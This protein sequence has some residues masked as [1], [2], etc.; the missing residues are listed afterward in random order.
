MNKL[1]QVFVW[2]LRAWPVIIL[3]LLICAHIALINRYLN[4]WSLIN[5]TISL[6]TQITGGLII[7][8]SI[9]SNIGIIKKL[10]L[11]EICTNYLK[12]FPS[13]RKNVTFETHGSN[14]VTMS[15]NAKLSF[16]RSPKSLEE[17]IDYLQKQITEV[18]QEIADQTKSLNERINKESSELKKLIENTKIELGQVK[19]QIEDVS[20]GGI[21][22]QFF[23]VLLI[24]YGS[25]TGYIA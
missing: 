7:L 15:P 22:I 13:F 12:E 24:I 18:K 23:G 3:V 2:F 21:K 17:K 6:I 20:I 11:F 8:Y 1:R 9:D 19:K 5:K 14:H 25:I 16:N 4:S 10:N